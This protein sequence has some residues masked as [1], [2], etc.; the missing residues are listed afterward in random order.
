MFIHETLVICR[1]STQICQSTKLKHH[2][3]FLL[4]RDII[5]GCLQPFTMLFLIG[6]AHFTARLFLFKM[7]LVYF[8]LVA[9]HEQMLGPD[10]KSYTYKVCKVMKFTN[11]NIWKIKL[12]L[13][14]FPSIYSPGNTIPSCMYDVYT[15]SLYLCQA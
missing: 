11:L 8:S 7:S 10:K 2:H 15:Y 14:A 9:I 1:V 3:I 5:F 6:P 13:R 12:I 4:C